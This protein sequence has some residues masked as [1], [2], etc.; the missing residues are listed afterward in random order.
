MVSTTSSEATTRGR[1][2]TTTASIIELGLHCV[3]RRTRPLRSS[4]LRWTIR[5]NRCRRLLE[6]RGLLR[7]ELRLISLRSVV[8]VIIL[9]L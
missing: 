4:R 8:G 2:S 6:L 3:L 7:V 5:D 9:R 1:A